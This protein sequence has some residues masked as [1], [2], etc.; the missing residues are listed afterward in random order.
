MHRPVFA[1]CGSSCPR[2]GAGDT[3]GLGRTPS[4]REWV[5]CLACRYVW[6]GS[7]ATAR[8]PGATEPHGLTD[9]LILDGDDVSLDTLEHTLGGYR[10]LTALDGDDG[11]MLARRCRPLVLV[12][13]EYLH[14]LS[15]ADVIETIRHER[16]ELNAVLLTRSGDGVD[17]DIAIDP[18]VHAL[19][20]RAAVGA[21][22]PLIAALIGRPR[23]APRRE[24]SQ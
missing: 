12:A 1:S 11:L 24:Q 13:D 18:Q 3:C 22:R 4:A 8:H 5:T 23:G 10:V 17:G 2:C 20:K 21:L 19:P 16:T 15:G 9:V 6:S 14:G 7:S